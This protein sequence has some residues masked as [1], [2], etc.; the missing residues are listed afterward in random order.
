MK[1]KRITVILV[2][3]SL[4]FS[5]CQS[6]LNADTALSEQLD[7][8]QTNEEGNA[9]LLTEDVL[10]TRVKAETITSPDGI[11]GL[12]NA[13]PVAD[14]MT[15]FGNENKLFHFSTETSSW[16]EVA[17]TPFA[18]YD[19]YYDAGGLVSVGED[20]I[21]RLTAMENHNNMN[22]ADGRED[23]YSFW[24]QYWSDY[25]TEYWLCTYTPDGTLIGKSKISGLE[26]YPDEDGNTQPYM[27]LW[28]EA[29]AF[30]TLQDGTILRIGEDG[31][32][33]KTEDVPEID[34]GI[35][36]DGIVRSF[37]CDRDGKILVYDTREYSEISDYTF[38]YE[39]TFRNFDFK[40][41]KVGDILYTG[42]ESFTGLNC[43]AVSGGY[44]DYRLFVNTENTLLGIKDNGET[45][46]VIDWDASDLEPMQTVP[47]PDG[48][49]LGFSYNA[50][51]NGAFYR[52]TR[53][54]KSESGEPKEITLAVLE[55]DYAVKDFV[56][57]FNRAHNN[58]RITIQPYTDS[59]E[60]TALE[61]LKMDIISDEA[62]DLVL[63][64]DN[65]EQF[66]KLGSK[67]VF[68]DLNEYLDSDTELNQKAL[69]SNVLPSI[70][71]PNGSLYA[72]PS[73]F[74]VE[75][76]AVKT[77]FT[78]KE[79]WTVDDMLTL[80]EGADDIFYYWSTKE[81]TLQMFLIG[82]D[83]TDE[84]TGTCSF[85][86]PEFVKILKF[87]NRYPAET[88]RPEK[89]YE[90]PEQNAKFEN[91][92]YDN[93][94]KYQRDQDYLY[95]FTISAPGGN[96]TLPSWSYVKAELGGEMTLT[97]Y[98]SGNGQGG[99][100]ATVSLK[101]YTQCGELGIVSTSPNRDTAWEVVKSY[102]QDGKE[103]NEHP[104]FSLIDAK[105]E[106][107][108]D[109]MMYVW[110]DGKRSDIPY[111]EDDGNNIYPLT[112]E[113]RDELECYIRNCDTFMMLDGT[114]KN[115]ILEETGMYF[116]G[117]R[118]AEETAKAIQ[119][120]AELYLSEQN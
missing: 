3:F 103:Y 63:M 91:W 118:S 100:I 113:E 90:N 120:R 31:S 61:Q 109:N 45:E 73:G 96:S 59:T 88:T 24:E 7:T 44:G 35:Q 50:D 48:S 25:V 82:T 40:T 56:K 49:F 5:G 106:E 81:D 116:S 10:T 18:P 33:T 95:P 21:H 29:G 119:S 110:N 26:E 42:D 17:L 67:A 65:H 87:C 46:T 107:Q 12:E 36:S 11:W 38:K 1:Y 9:V 14:G 16:T 4:L 79:S 53:L 93:F 111:I 8:V 78:D 114:V 75:T 104:S 112:Q 102:V 15:V 71:H 89:N 115:I 68:C 43:R 27:F 23:D 34:G 6:A 72:L 85:D 2:A 13:K 77:K 22:P 83:F 99:K 64:Y 60:K 28:D 55:R 97:G 70:Q 41:G 86:S 58:I 94:M 105:F 39:Q 117:D 19:G 98:P 80:Y 37:L 20:A 47:L 62:P 32:V 54:H 108:M 69:V 92:Y 84:L 51:G 57:A 74:V 52:L 66:L 30:L 76:I 101:S